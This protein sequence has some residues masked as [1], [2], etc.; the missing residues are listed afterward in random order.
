MPQQVL[1]DGRLQR[2]CQ[3]CGR[4]HDL[5]AFDGS[6]KSC[7]DQLSKH[8]ARRRRRAQAEQAKGKPTDATPMGGSAVGLAAAGMPLDGDVGRLLASLMQNP[9][10]L[11]A[12]RLLLGVSTHPALPAAQ[13]AAAVAGIIG[14]NEDADAGRSDQARTYALARD[15]LAGRNEFSPAFESE[16]RMVRLSMKLFNRTPADLP[17]DLRNQITSWLASAPAAMEASIRPG[18]VFLT[19][20]MLVDEVVAAQVAA[21]GALKSLCE[22][23]V[24]RTGSPFWSS[25]MYT[26]QLGTD[27]LLVRDGR[28]CP[29]KCADGRFPVISR[30]GPLAAVAGKPAVLKLTGHNLDAPGC[31]VSRMAPGC[32]ESV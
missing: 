13:P 12:L 29:D 23:L 6:R 14:A 1:K 25:G 7:R 11:H 24:H 4:F 20:Q 27:I 5:T 19:V 28:L 30:L 32:R 18:C 15:I 3:Q 2:F 10:Q 8:N 17:A 16:H 22:H 9:T 21:P 31:V 26:V